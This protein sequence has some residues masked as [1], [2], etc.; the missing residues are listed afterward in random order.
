MVFLRLEVFEQ[1]SLSR[2]DQTEQAIPS[3]PR[4]MM[5]DNI[6]HG[7]PLMAISLDRRW[8]YVGPGT[9]LCVIITGASGLGHSWLILPLRR[10]IWWDFTLLIYSQ[11]DTRGSFPTLSTCRWLQSFGFSFRRLKLLLEAG[12]YLNYSIAAFF[13]WSK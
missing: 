3:R 10:N 1:F 11:Y 5:W 2:W 4:L 9:L 13:V 8:Y 7:L 12:F 6:C